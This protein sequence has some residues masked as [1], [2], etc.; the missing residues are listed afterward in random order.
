MG[1]DFVGQVLHFWK[2]VFVEIFLCRVIA[3]HDTDIHHVSQALGA[4]TLE[5][6]ADDSKGLA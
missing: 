2:V 1:V 4:K 6:L 5:V 3:H